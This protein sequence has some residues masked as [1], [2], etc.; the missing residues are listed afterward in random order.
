MQK[1]SLISE[2]YSNSPLLGGYKI[3]VPD[4]SFL[5]FIRAEKIVEYGCFIKEDN[6][7]P[8][9]FKYADNTKL[10]EFSKDFIER[11]KQ[12]ESFRIYSQQESFFNPEKGN[13]TEHFELH[14]NVLAWLAKQIKSP[15]P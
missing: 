8:E 2:A 9:Y 15:S 14:E 10:R 1:N 12:Y 11:V 5:S 13:I 4:S 3:K 6:K 7:L